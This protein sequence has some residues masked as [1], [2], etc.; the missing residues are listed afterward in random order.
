MNE[1][2]EPRDAVLTLAWETVP[3][4]PEGF[5]VAIP[6]WLDIDGACHPHEAEVSVP[7]NTRAFSFVMDPPWTANFSA[8]TLVVA[9]HLHDGGENLEI[10]K[11]GQPYCNSVAKYGESAGYISGMPA[12]PGMNMGGSMPRAMS[13]SHIS[14]MSG[15][16]AQEPIKPG[17]RWSVRANYNLTEHA[18]MMEQENIPAPIMG[19]GF[20]YIAKV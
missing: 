19:I 17:D 9:G 8:K 5:E 1:I 12:M 11:N 10:M 16:S 4:L 14:S 15:C 13:T 3:G 18:P 7:N 20:M 2:P 6:I